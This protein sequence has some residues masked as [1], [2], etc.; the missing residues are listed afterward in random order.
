MS[1][2]SSAI[3]ARSTARP[4]SDADTREHRRH[5]LRRLD[6]LLRGA[7]LEAGLLGEVLDHELDVLGLGVQARAHGRGAD[8]LLEQAVGR[9]AIRPRARRIVSA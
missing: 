3:L 8:V 2:R 9:S 1:S 7:Q 4:R 5:R 6:E